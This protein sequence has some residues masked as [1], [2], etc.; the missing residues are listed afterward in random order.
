MKLL[1]LCALAGCALALVDRDFSE[2][3]WA[4]WTAA[5]SGF[6]LR[7]EYVAARLSK[8]TENL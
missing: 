1:F 6:A 4:A 2:A 3:M 7:S 5:G 8:T